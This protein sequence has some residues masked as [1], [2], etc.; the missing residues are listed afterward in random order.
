MGVTI[1]FLSASIYLYIMEN[2][3]LVSLIHCI[4]YLVSS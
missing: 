3:I 2:Q 1:L 4:G